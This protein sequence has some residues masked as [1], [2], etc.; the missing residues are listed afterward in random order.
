MFNSYFTEV[1]VLLSTVIS[2]VAYEKKVKI[3]LTEKH[4]YDIKKEMG[5][6]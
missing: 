6:T 1:I 4:R 5:M 2:P 3:K